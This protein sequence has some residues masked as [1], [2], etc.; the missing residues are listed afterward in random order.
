MEL[1]RDYR[2]DYDRIYTMYKRDVRTGWFFVGGSILIISLD[3]IILGLQYPHIH[4]DF[5][6]RTLWALYFP[7]LTVIYFVRRKNYHKNWLYLCEFYFNDS[8]QEFSSKLPTCNDYS[9]LK[10]AYILRQT[11]YDNMKGIN[12]DNQSEKY[13]LLIDEMHKRDLIGEVNR[14]KLAVHENEFKRLMFAEDLGYEG[15]HLVVTDKLVLIII[16]YNN[17]LRPEQIIRHEQIIN[18]RCGFHYGS[19]TAFFAKAL[20]IHYMN[21]SKRKKRI[22]FSIHCEE[23][24]KEIEARRKKSENNDTVMM[25][26]LL[27]KD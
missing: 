3:L 15:M 11:N 25:S 2:M 9:L 20:E 7:L 22:L 8:Y 27:G 1:P 4:K 26:S 10:T 17:V 23:L 12:D 16:V 24:K 21:K 19:T 18:L 6:Y 14:D 5:F 13:Y